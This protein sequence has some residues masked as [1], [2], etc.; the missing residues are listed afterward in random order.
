MRMWARSLALLK[1]VK[2]PSLLWLWHR[3]A[4]IAQS[5]PLAWELPYAADV[6]IQKKKKKIPGDLIYGGVF[7]HPCPSGN[8]R[9]DLGTTQSRA[10]THQI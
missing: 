7:K 6:A 5:Q 3:L 1:W 8:P 10:Q 4:A 9:I 2:D